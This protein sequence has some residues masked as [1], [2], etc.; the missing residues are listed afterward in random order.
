MPNTVSMTAPMDV[1]AQEAAI[2]RQRRLA[3]ML[4]QQ[5]MEQQQGQTVPGGFYV[6]PSPVQGVA[7]L[8]QA[9][10]A[11]RQQE[12]ADRKQ[13]ELS[14]RQRQSLVDGL[15]NYQ[16]AMQGTPAET[17]TPDGD[18]M[19]PAGTQPAVPGNRQAALAALLR[20]EHPV[21]QQLGIAEM[22]KKP[23]SQF[24]K[25]DA[26]DYTQESVLK[27]SQT[28]NFADLVPVRKM[29]FVNDQ[30]VNPFDTKPG[31]IVP[32]QA[33][34]ASDLLIPDGNGGFVPNAQLVEVK[35]GIAKSGAP[36]V[37]VKTDIKMNEG[38]ANQVGPMMKE[39]VIAATGAAQQVD[40][41][42]RIIQAVDTNK[43][44][45][46]PMA[47]T[48]LKIAQVGDLIG[49]GGKDE[50]EK[51]ANTRQAI[52][53]L[54]EMTL[55]GRKSMR[56]EGAITE[57]EGKLAERTF[58][59]DINELTPAEIRQL[60]KASERAARFLHG[61]HNR[62]VEQMRKT[63]GLENVTPFY[64]VPPIPEPAQAAPGQTGGLSQS[65]Q[66]ELQQLRQ[67]LGRNK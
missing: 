4:Q 19:G 62:K 25:V 63:P 57:S 56:G 48:R 66:Q 13:S 50:Q 49:V 18:G 15:T 34:M 10:V 43:I 17:F 14:D 46:G 55:Q 58:S 30:A 2:A 67:R 12:S 32:K 28:Q 44:Y 6:P 1:Q 16:N 38:I 29:E 54:S 40:A 22:T 60:A 36:S 21:L 41:A 5:S 64:E 42:N 45:A 31:T 37:N 65:E 27:F 52:R 3:E 59:G 61:E 11:S 33:N 9:L 8:V 51:I 26:K 23:E 24:N 20:S 39:S 7:K 53:G 35:K 47:T